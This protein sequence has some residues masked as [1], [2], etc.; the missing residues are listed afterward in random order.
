MQ[1]QYTITNT[2]KIEIKQRNCHN[3]L[4]KE[5]LDEETEDNKCSNFSTT[6]NL[7]IE[8]EILDKR[9]IYNIE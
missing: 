6:W 5:Y 7:W 4:I 9:E 2:S 8:K 3:I 1:P